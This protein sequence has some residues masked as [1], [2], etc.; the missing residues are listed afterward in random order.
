M[1]EKTTKPTSSEVRAKIYEVIFGVDTPS[2]KLFDVLLLVFIL[3][4]VLAV[5][6]ESVKPLSDKYHTVFFVLEWSLTILFS[7]EYGLR[8]YSVG[9]PLQYATSFFGVIDLISILPTYLSLLLPGS[10]MLLVVRALRLLRIFRILKLARYL[11][12]AATITQALRDSRAKIT[13][14]LVFVLTMV[15]IVGS[16]MYLIEGGQ[17][18][19]FDSIPAS[20]YWAIV[21]LTTVGF[22]DITPVTPLG[23]FLSAALMI[24]GYGVIA[25]PTGIVTARIA[26]AKGK[27][28]SVPIEDACNNCGKGGHDSDASYCKHCG[29]TL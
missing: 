12:E 14:F 2:G 9:K 26:Y 27:E 29:S 3:I 22:G 1:K 28:E 20:M 16:A 21:T 8:L 13:V 7:I 23:Q 18:N 17:N 11:R 4:S 5:V 19:G 15:L 10:H 24:M 6:L 25:V